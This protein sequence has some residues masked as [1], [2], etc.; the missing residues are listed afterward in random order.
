M[1]QIKS[2]INNQKW[3]SIVNNR[4]TVPLSISKILSH[5]P[6]VSYWSTLR[7]ANCTDGAAPYKFD[8]FLKKNF[9]KIPQRTCFQNRVKTFWK[10]HLSSPLDKSTQDLFSSVTEGS[11]HDGQLCIYLFFNHP[12]S[13]Q[14]RSSAAHDQNLMQKVELRMREGEM[15]SRRNKWSNSA[16]N[17]QGISEITPACAIF[18]Y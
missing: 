10:T 8:L 4:V 5:S 14:R 11:V 7:R 2:R 16:G 15:Q 9:K 17:F 3:F 1:P 6:Q 13:S 18:S 12:L